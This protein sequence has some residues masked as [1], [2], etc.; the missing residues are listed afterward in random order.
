[1]PLPGE[2]GAQQPVD[3]HAAVEFLAEVLPA[4]VG[5]A[6]AE[7][8]LQ[9]EVDAGPP[10]GAHRGGGV[11]A[12]AVRA[13]VVQQAGVGEGGDFGPHR[14]FACLPGV[15]RDRRGVCG[16]AK[17]LGVAGHEF[18]GRDRAAVVGPGRVGGQDGP[19][20]GHPVEREG[21]VRLG[22]VEAGLGVGEAF[23]ALGRGVE[24]VAEEEGLLRGE[25][26]VRFG[27]CGGVAPLYVDES[28]GPP[29]RVGH[30]GH[31]VGALVVVRLPAQER[32]DGDG[33]GGGR[34][35]GGLFQEGRAEA[36]PAGGGPVVD[37]DEQSGATG[38]ERDAEGVPLRAGQ[39]AF[40]DPAA[41]Q[42]LDARRIGGT[43]RVRVVQGV[44]VVQGVRCRCAAGGR[45]PVALPLTVRHLLLA[46][47]GRRL[48]G[49]VAGGPGLS[50]V[51]GGGR[52]VGLGRGGG[53][54]GG[55]SCDGFRGQRIAAVA[56]RRYGERAAAASASARRSTTA[57][58]CSSVSVRG[59][60]R[61][62][63]VE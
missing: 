43:Q 31:H 63:T 15:E 54:H 53:V 57:V 55:L 52:A 24:R 33:V 45:R 17:A 41:E 7:G 40:A 32:G 36:V 46:R 5:D 11:P 39:V 44:L 37:G 22:R 60:S 58:A 2:S 21:A 34:A 30:P 1:M 59:G 38:G 12:L 23:A 10:D 4:G 19:V 56:V 18:R 28:G 6:Y 29:Y 25:E 47:H 61:R 27:G 50:P 14:Q 48:D 42:V 9:H 35:F 62:T 3:L 8:E 13:E 26:E 16:D 51:M 20:D 49:E